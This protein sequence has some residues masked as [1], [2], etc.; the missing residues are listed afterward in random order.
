[1][2]GHQFESSWCPPAMRGLAARVSG[3]QHFDPVL[4]LKEKRSEYD[5]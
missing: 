1:M 2:G 5:G 4:C 3:S